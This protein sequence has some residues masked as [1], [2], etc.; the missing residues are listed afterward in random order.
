M[1]SVDAIDF[2]NLDVKL[3][4]RVGWDGSLSSRSVGIVGWAGQL[5]LGAFSEAFESLVPTLDDH[6]GTDSEGQGLV[7]VVAGIKLGAVEEGAAIVGLDLVTLLDLVAF[8]FFLDVH[9]ELVLF[10]LHRFFGGLWL[11][12]SFN[13]DDFD[14][15]EKDRVGR[16]LTAGLGAIGHP[17]WADKLSLG[18][19]S[20][21]F[22]SLVPTLDH[23]TGTDSEGQ[24]LVPVVAGIE[25]GA[26]KEG[27]AIVG[28]DLVT[29]LDLV[30]FAFLGDGHREL[31]LFFH[32]LWLLHG[33]DVNNLDVELE[34]RVAGDGSCCS[35]TVCKVG[36][37]S[38][39]SLGAYSESHKSFIPAL[40]NVTRA[41]SEDDGLS[42]VV[43]G[44]E[45]GAVKESAS[46]VGMDLVSSLELV[47]FTF[48]F[49]VDRE[50]WLIWLLFLRLDGDNFDVKE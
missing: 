10:L 4:D 14:A 50:S 27:A 35:S 23:H 47:A 9:G 1:H 42:P 29:L 40:N 3:E 31:V 36:W 48:L 37:A 49:D 18:A 26:V 30:A 25:L 39:L 33:L 43:A 2:N 8:T 44:I 46:V 6:T 41:N 7:P 16:D 17:R 22:E 45:L 32:R 24:G 38:Q 19:F 28:L 13:V 34:D 5:G 11:V 15:E 21:A 12:F 20:E